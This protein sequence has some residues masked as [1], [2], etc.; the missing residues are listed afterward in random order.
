MK[1]LRPVGQVELVAV[2]NLT[3]AF[4]DQMSACG[5]NRLTI[6]SLAGIASS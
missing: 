6:L 1:P 5:S 4:D 3:A 2:L